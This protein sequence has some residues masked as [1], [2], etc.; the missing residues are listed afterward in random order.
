MATLLLIIGMF[1]YLGFPIHLILGIVNPK[2]AFFNKYKNNLESKGPTKIEAVLLSF[3]LLIIGTT[4]G[5]LAI[6]I[7]PNVGET[8]VGTTYKVTEIYDGDTITVVNKDNNAQKIRLACIDAPEAE[9]PQGKL[10]TTTLNNFIPIGTNVE[11]NVI[12]TDQYGRTIAEVLKNKVNINQSMLKKGQAIIYHEYLSNC[13]DGN[14]YI[15]AEALAKDQ[16]L[17]VW[18]DSNFI[19]PKNWRNGSRPKVLRM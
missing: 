13:P 18:N 19:T 8:E 5:V 10:S 11:I 3:E 4:A 12:D 2:L 7:D 16:E 9:Q 14:A 17:G 6:I 15:E 1:L